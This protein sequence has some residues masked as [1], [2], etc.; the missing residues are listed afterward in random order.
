VFHDLL[1]ASV[2]QEISRYDVTFASIL[3]GPPL[4]VSPSFLLKGLVSRAR[5]HSHPGRCHTYIGPY[6]HLKMPF[7]KMRPYVQV[8]DITLYGVNY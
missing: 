3:P 5:T 8:P 7:F 6:I 1:L 2:V 4:L